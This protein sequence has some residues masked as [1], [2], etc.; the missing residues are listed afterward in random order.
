MNN[1]ILS[2]IIPAYNVEK[3]I[4]RC[5]DSLVNQTI[6]EKIEVI[7][8]NDGSTDKTKEYAEKYIKKYSNIFLY[9]QKNRGV[10]NARNLGIDK[11]IGKYITFLDT[12]DWVDLNC[13]EKMCSVLEQENV[14]IVVTGLSIDGDNRC[15]VK[16]R[17]AKC[18]KR[19][20]R[21]SAI[22]SYLKGNLDVHIV[23]KVFRRN[24]IYNLKFD[25]NIKIAEDRLFLYEC[26]LKAHEIYLLPDCF[27]H[28]FQNNESVMNQPFTQKKFDNI[29]V[30]NKIKELTN[31]YIKELKPYADAMYISM[32]CRLYGEIW[33][34]SE[35]YF[36]EYMK[37]KN[38]VKRYKI[39]YAFKYM[40]K[41]HF[42]AF[43][44]AQISPRLF[45]L[46]RG[47][48]VMKFK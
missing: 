42:I 15:M 45:K 1:Y 16:K 35:N 18:E 27:Y 47:N 12:D 25:E 2:V 46:L 36:D 8:V 31:K 40:S 9:N 48:L 39:R 3:Y 5:L 37:L 23:N 14:D 4:D 20:D 43:L 21:N 29:I 24:I 10:S 41:K 26:L 30:G 34:H 33:E 11:A 32:E 38:D 22:K 44:I 19:L 7:I 6:F 17:L 28:Y 13:Y